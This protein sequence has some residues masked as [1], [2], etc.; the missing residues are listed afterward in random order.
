LV[1]TAETPVLLRTFNNPTPAA[2]D[3]FG[4]W[5]ASVG[6]DRVLVS[7]PYDDT[8]A[9]NAGIVYLYH[10]NGTLLTT[11]TNP[12]P[13]NS[14]F[15][16]DLFGNAIA[17]LGNE[18]VLVGAPNERAVY[19]FATNGV[20]MKIIDSVNY[21][22]DI[23]FG[24]AVVGIGNDRV[25]I[26]AP[27]HTENPGFD[28]YMGA[29]YLYHTNGALLATFSNPD[30]HEGDGFGFSL[31]AFGSDR[32]LVGS[33]SY[34]PGAAYLFN[35]NG[36]L[37]TTITNPTPAAFDYFGHSVA[38]IGT[39]RV[40]VGAY[41][42]DSAT[43]NAGT[44]YLF[45]TNGILQMTIANPTP[46]VEDNF[47]N[48]IAVLGNNRV[49]IGAPGDDTTGPDAGSAYVFDIN[50]SLLATINNPAPAAGDR[51]GS[52]IAPFG[53]EGVIIGAALD[54]AGATD[55]GS[56]Y[57]FIIPDS[58][59]APSLTID[60]TGPNSIVVSWPSL[61]A[62]FVL[63]QN[64]NGAK[65]VNWSNVTATIQDD[66]TTKSL[67]VTPGSGACFYRLVKP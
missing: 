1:A 14:F 29:A 19:L 15:D 9:T 46:A 4:T 2:G 10:T 44:I 3:N 21:P 8:T 43:T 58:S 36:T 42:D 35:T 38:A 16:A 39:D 32:V 13:A 66:G 30:P 62:G 5:M 60:R 25:L 54:D 6:N 49:I 52:R 17:A 33:R 63:Q 55:A 57:L 65:S 23:S 48:R 12:S 34:G 64:T 51:F 67:G 37:L 22:E 61:S 41:N 7:A 20:L 28:D 50:G 47:G 31:A 59:V 56:A 11:F 45:N 40:L 53:S 18:S 26:G 24:A 27:D